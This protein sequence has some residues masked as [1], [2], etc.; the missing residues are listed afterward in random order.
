MGRNT[1]ERAKLLT[2]NFMKYHEEG[3]SIAEM[4]KKCKLSSSV[5]YK[6]HLQK[7]ADANHVSRDSL[8]FR[9]YAKH[10]PKKTVSKSIAQNKHVKKKKV[11]P[12]NILRMCDTTIRTARKLEEEIR[13]VLE[14]N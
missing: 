12:E 10:S 9:V 11:N 6:V 5:I 8:L 14:E 2:T 1:S 4:A 7:I 3:L 13:T